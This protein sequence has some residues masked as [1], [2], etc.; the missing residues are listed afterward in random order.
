METHTIMV[1]RWNP[2]D[3][4]RRLTDELR[5]APK[6]VPKDAV[7]RCVLRTPAHVGFGLHRRLISVDILM[8]RTFVSANDFFVAGL[9]A[10]RKGYGQY[11]C[12]DSFIREKEAIGH[13]RTVTRGGATRIPRWSR[14][15]VSDLSESLPEVV[16]ATRGFWIGSGGLD[17][18]G[19]LPDLDLRG[20]IGNHKDLLTHSIMMVA[21]AEAVLVDLN[22]LI[23]LTHEHLP[24]D[25]DPLGDS[26]G[27]VC[28]R[29]STGAHTGDDVGIICH[30]AVDG[31]LQVAAYKDLPFHAPM[32]I[33]QALFEANDATETINVARNR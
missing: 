6:S 10:A 7:V 16:G 26:L 1:N 32:E 5:T 18:N 27:Q 3:R 9:K 33:H 21:T 17:A 4:I 30:L 24:N 22:A 29:T 8:K 19:G 14:S 2:N 13:G 25:R 12:R 31:T 15:L 23:L 28:G 20:G 11:F